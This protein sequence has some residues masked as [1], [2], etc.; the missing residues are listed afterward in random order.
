MGK[1]RAYKEQRGNLEGTDSM[2]R[3]TNCREDCLRDELLW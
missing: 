1:N 2:N 3:T